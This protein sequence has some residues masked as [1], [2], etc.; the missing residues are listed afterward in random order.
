VIARARGLGSAVALIVPP[1]PAA[2]AGVYQAG[3]AYRDCVRALAQ[4]EGLPVV[5]A[6]ALFAAHTGESLFV[7]WVHPNR[8]GHQLLA[9]RLFECVRGLVPTRPTPPRSAAPTLASV[10]PNVVAA[11]APTAIVV[12]GNGLGAPQAFDRLF[13]G[14]RWL[15]GITALDADR[16]QVQ[17]TRSLAPGVHAVSLRTAQ[18]LVR[19]EVRLEVTPPRPPQ[20]RVELLA[21]AAAPTLRLSGAAPV[22][23]AVVVWFAAARGAPVAT[24]FGD[25]HL[26]LPS[27][28]TA[29]APF[30]LDA[31]PL[32]RAIV[33]SHTGGFQ[34]DWPVPAALAASPVLYAQAGIRDAF[35]PT[36]GV[37]TEV[38]TIEL[39][40]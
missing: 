26:Q 15:P 10:S 8:R 31:L 20:L 38:A 34:V 9:E 39:R 17:L 30:V 23:M 18:G 35:D 33:G 5:D 2:T 37:L 40:R 22:E 4:S 21:G 36:F 12:T 28:A 25:F 11:L 32:P 3:A 1:V 27:E 14:D 6:D 29:G 13:L 19:S 7:D 24:A 16:V